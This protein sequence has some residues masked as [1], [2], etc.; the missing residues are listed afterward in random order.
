MVLCS[1]LLCLVLAVPGC[2]SLQSVHSESLHEEPM[3]HISEDVL[4]VSSIPL[5][6][7]VF[8]FEKKQKERFPPDPNNDLDKYPEKGLVQMHT[9]ENTALQHTTGPFSRKPV[10]KTPVTIKVPAGMY[11]VGV[12][13]DVASENIP[14]QYFGE[15]EDSEEYAEAFKWFSGTQELEIYANLGPLNVGLG[16]FG[17]LSPYLYDDNLEFWALYSKGL[18][19]KVG[20]T[21]EVE[22]KQGET[23]AVIALFQRKN[24]DPDKIYNA[25]PEEYR[26]N[27]RINLI[28]DIIEIWGVPKNMSKPLY[29]RVLRGGKAMVYDSQSDCILIELTPLGPAASGKGE[30]AA[31][32]TRIIG[33]S[34]RND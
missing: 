32:T 29:R 17:H 27:K 25:L 18:L 14:F 10:G 26:F 13:L 2:T 8:V 16:E 6:A 21:Y 3:P 22:K 9:L 15:A 30:R 33:F 23:A 19:K 28:P 24:E 5:G 34:L 7:D 4:W 11:C 20:K 1:T 12:Q 31:Y